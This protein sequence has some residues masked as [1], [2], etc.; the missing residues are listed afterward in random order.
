MCTECNGLG[1]RPEMDP[2][3]IVPD[4]TRTIREGAIEPWASGLHRGEGWTA[5]TLASHGM[6]A[7][8]ASFVPLDRSADVF[9]RDPV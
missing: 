2:D 5:E 6:P 1:T 3:L 4:P 9:S 8:K 7:L